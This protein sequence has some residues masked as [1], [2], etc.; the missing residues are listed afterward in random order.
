M[1]H[2][3]ASAPLRLVWLVL[4]TLCAAQILAVVSADAVEKLRIGMVPDAGATQVSVEEKAP[5]RAYLEKATG[6]KVELVIPTN[7]NATVE[8][9]GNGSLDVA[10]LGGLTYLKARERYGVTPL[11]QRES[12]K[13]FHS[14][15]ITGAESGIDS[16]DDL[17]G[18]RFAFGDINSTSGHL[19]PDLALRQ[20]GLDPDKDLSF[21]Y[22]GSHIA[23]IKAVEAGAADA[24][25]V[26]ESVFRQ[27]TQ[28]GKAD[29]A[30]LRVFYVTPAFL[31][32]VWAARKD[33]DKEASAAVAKAF[34]ELQAG[35]PDDDKVLAV[36]RGT[37]FVAVDDEEYDQLRAVA[38][39]LGLL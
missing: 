13:A 34:M 8:G 12:D 3:K 20:A 29:G 23:T 27:A 9:L 5:L 26:D 25:A 30:K 36:L 22:T 33:L 1:R 16:L 35:R 28:D 18:K 15:F 32:Y 6:R 4:A 38:R 14:N 39:S 2:E 19:M 7:Y 17:K 37:R 10:Y 11:T 31:D 21:R 24:G